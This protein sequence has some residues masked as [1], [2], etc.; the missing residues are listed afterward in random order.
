MVSASQPNP[1]LSIGFCDQSSSP[2]DGISVVSICAAWR[3]NLLLR[4]LVLYPAGFESL[5]GF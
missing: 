5:R 3:G 2:W 1:F 4:A